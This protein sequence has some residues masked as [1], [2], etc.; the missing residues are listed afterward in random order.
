MEGNEL[1]G[2]PCGLLKINLFRIR[3]KNNFMNPVFWVENS[4]N[5]PQRLSD[6]CCHFLKKSVDKD[7]EITENF[8]EEIIKQLVGY[9]SLLGC[10]TL[11]RKNF[12]V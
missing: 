11:N 4:T 2:L 10:F 12:Y 9:V 3:I 8:P 1:P 5:A 7:K 6:I